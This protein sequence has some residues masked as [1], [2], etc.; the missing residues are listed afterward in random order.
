MTA[1]DDP[2]V[3]GKYHLLATLGRGGMAEVFLAVIQGPAGFSKLVVLKELRPEL[4]SEPEFLSMFLDEARL[5]ARLQ[6]PN[7]VQT[8]EVGHE[9]SRHFIAM[10][11]LDGQP[12][13]RVLSRMRGQLPLPLHLRVLSETLA[14]LHYAHELRDFDGTPLAVVHRDVTPHNVFVTYDGEVKLV[15]FGIAKATDSSTETRTGVLKGADCAGGQRRDA[16]GRRLLRHLGALR[17]R[18]S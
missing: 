9:G 16:S 8:N 12:L 2:N 7:V 15:D 18:G 6:H 4:S 5:A 14:A 10:E 17:R 3:I 1:P 13:S 11:Y